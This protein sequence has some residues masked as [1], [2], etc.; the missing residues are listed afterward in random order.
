M[1]IRLEPADIFLTRGSGFLSWAVRFFTRTI[2]ESRTRVNHCGVI[3]EGGPPR[4]A[5][6]IEALARVRRH[7]LGEQ[8]GGD[9]KQSVAVYRAKG[10]APEDVEAVVA[11]AGHYEGKRYAWWKIL[12]HLL[13]WLL[14]GAY[15]FRRL[16]WMDRYPICS[17]LVAYSFEKAGIEFGVAPKAATPDDIWD[18]IQAHPEAWEEILPLQPLSD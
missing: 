18:H 1:N 9:P 2:G 16:A 12:A 7:P 10:L 6:A 17:W 11:A 14:L 5:V 4:T 13:D 8:Y 15:L 3:V